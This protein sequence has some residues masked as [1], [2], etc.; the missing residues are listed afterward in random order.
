MLTLG[1]INYFESRN[2]RVISRPRCLALLSE[3]GQTEYHGVIVTIPTLYSVILG[4]YLD[5]RSDCRHRDE[6]FHRCPPFLWSMPA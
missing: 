6:D 3:Q 4:S 2:C 5:P 1:D